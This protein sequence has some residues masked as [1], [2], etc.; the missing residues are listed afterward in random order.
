MLAQGTRSLTLHRGLRA[1]GDWRLK[2]STQPLGMRARMK[3]AE[4][5]RVLSDDRE[6][7]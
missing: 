7:L 3:R 5:K 2:P 6:A 4:V 1:D